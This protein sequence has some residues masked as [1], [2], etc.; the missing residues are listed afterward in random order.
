LT[1][2]GYN[3]T[4]S[5]RAKY[6]GMRQNHD[7]IQK[8]ISYTALLDCTADRPVFLQSLEPHLAVLNKTGGH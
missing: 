8:V 4:K 1:G 7:A 6:D 5:Q 3:P 2:S